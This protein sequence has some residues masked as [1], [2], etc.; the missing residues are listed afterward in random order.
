VTPDGQRFIFATL[1]GSVPTPLV[2]VAN[3]SA[4]EE[5][6]TALVLNPNARTGKQVPSQD[7]DHA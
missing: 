7:C 6:V 1:P 2:P 3:W 5:V 4:P